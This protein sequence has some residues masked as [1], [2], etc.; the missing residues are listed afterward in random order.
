MGHSLL[1][2]RLDSA[3]RFFLYVLIFWLPYSPAVIEICVIVCLVLWLMKRSLL[4]FKQKMNDG[5]VVQ[6]LCAILSAFKP[7]DTFLNRPIALFL[8]V[9]ILSAAG[10]AF[11]GQSLHNLLTKTLE[12][13]IVYF[14]T[15]E[16]FQRKKHIYIAISVFAFTA[17]STVID[18]LVQFYITNKDIFN[19]HVIEP[20]SRATAGFKTPNGLGGYLTIFIPGLLAWILLGKQKLRYL[21]IMIPILLLS[22]WS[23][24]TTLSRGAWMGVFLG[25]LLLLLLILLPGRKVEFYF[26]LGIIGIILGLFFVFFL[27]LINGPGQEFL[28]RY[29]SIHMRTGIWKDS[30]NMIRDKP[31]FGH[32]IN[33]FMMVFQ[34]YRQNPNMDPTYA[35]NCYIQMA[36]EVGLT[37]LFAF[38]WIMAQ[39]FHQPLR[40]IKLGLA[41]D[42]NMTAL[43]AGLL[44]GIFAFLIHSLFDTNFY[45]LQLSVYLWVMVG[46]LVAIMKI[47]DAP[48][49]Y[50]R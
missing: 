3:I 36:S 10:S 15:V 14:L 48:V 12:W 13:F 25:A 50:G 40:K 16:V 30:L 11:W 38:F 2:D 17:F 23:L 24:M 46:T 34:A 28:S 33:T 39:A 44:C 29:H 47:S 31:I 4:L 9:C 32:G 49:G 27:I 21:P 37:G 19:G 35:H 45:S 1:T 41:Q 22:V 5:N 8:L 7:K 6:K 43:T 26:S 20:G 42:Q 18:S